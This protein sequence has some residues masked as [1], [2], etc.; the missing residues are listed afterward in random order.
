MHVRPCSRMLFVII[1]EKPR[2]H[3]GEYA[4]RF[5]VVGP[6]RTYACRHFYLKDTT[7]SQIVE[8]VCRFVYRG[9]ERIVFLEATGEGIYRDSWNYPPRLT[10][11]SG[12]WP[13]SFAVRL[14]D[15]GHAKRTDHRAPLWPKKDSIRA[16]KAFDT[17]PASIEEV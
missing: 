3:E 17:V 12:K 5:V 16:C 9:Q 15:V 14:K 6:R 7:L 13:I 1:Y 4:G 11:R 2:G 8:N 10:P